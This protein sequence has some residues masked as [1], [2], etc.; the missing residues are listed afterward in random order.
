[1]LDDLAEME[2]GRAL[3]DAG[4]LLHRMGDDDDGVT[5]LELV[6]QLLDPGGRDRIERLAR[7]VHQDHL[8]VDRNGPGDAQP[9]LLP[10]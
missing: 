5:A 1:M 3:R 2:E 8:G 9:L 10:T 4:C 6:D 7:L